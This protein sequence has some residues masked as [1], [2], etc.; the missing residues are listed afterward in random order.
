MRSQK[1]KRAP[2]DTQALLLKEGKRARDTCCTRVT[3]VVHPAGAA[4]AGAL[5]V[6]SFV[7]PSRRE[8]LTNF[9][10]LTGLP[11]EV[12]VAL[13]VTGLKLLC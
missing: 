8:L 1:I 7:S 9:T 4:S 3:G 12:A 5:S 10:N 11:Q 13:W 6:R 2:K